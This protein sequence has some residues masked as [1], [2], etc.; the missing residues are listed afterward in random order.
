MKYSIA[1]AFAVLF[2]ILLSR[3]TTPS[4]SLTDKVCEQ[5]MY[6]IKNLYQ[7]SKQD[8]QILMALVHITT[9]SAKL[10]MLNSLMTNSE[11]QKRL[12]VDLVELNSSIL[13]YQNTVLR[14]FEELAP[15]VALPK[16]TN[17][18]AELFS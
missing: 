12:G 13:K 18:D 9:A 1:V 4:C 2:L 6:Q 3:L 11:A 5:Q 7:A 15:E 17:V 16:D 8:S 10:Q 14:G